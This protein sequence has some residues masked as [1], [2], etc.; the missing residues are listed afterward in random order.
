VSASTHTEIYRR[1]EGEL[2]PARPRF[3]PLW[4]ARV[5][6]GQKSKIA[7]L[8]LYAPPAISGVVFSFIV[9]LKFT[10]ES[11][12]RAP[13]GLD[14]LAAAMALTMSDRL[15]QVHEQVVHFLRVSRAFALLAIAWYG[16]GLICEDRRAGAHLLY[17]SRPLTRRDYH[18][19]QLAT[20]TTFGLRAVLWPALLILLVA[21]FSSPEYAFVRQKW[22][23]ILATFAFAVLYVAVMASLVLAISSLS[24]RKMYALGAVFAVAVGSEV[25]GEMMAQLRRSS[26]WRM[27]S[28]AKN[29]DRILYW[30]L[31]IEPARQVQF[32]F[33]GEWSPW[34]SVAVVGG[35]ALVSTATVAWR[36]RRMEVVA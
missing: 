23:V 1:F 10:A 25:V 35:L 30:M 28:I 13:G 20:A 14:P 8:L 27:L 16:A 33:R 18:L 24:A 15:I 2:R 12:V 36:L 26:E 29:F 5:A 31:E 9:Y 11:Q 17:F 32:G 21:S 22:P 6:A 7:L 4:R 19:A 3:A 34:L